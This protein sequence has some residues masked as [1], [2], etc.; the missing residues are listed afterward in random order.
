MRGSTMPHLE[1]NNEEIW[2]RRAWSDEERSRQ[3]LL[4]EEGVYYTE[5]ERS[6]LCLLVCFLLQQLHHSW[7]HLLGFDARLGIEV[8]KAER[9]L[10]STSSMREEAQASYCMVLWN[11]PRL[12]N[13]HIAERDQSCPKARC[14][15]HG[16]CH[17]QSLTRTGCGLAQFPLRYEHR[18][19]FGMPQANVLPI[20]EPLGE[21]Q[22]LAVPFLGLYK[23]ASTHLKLC[24]VRENNGDQGAIANPLGKAARTTQGGMGSLVFATIE[25][26]VADIT[27]HMSNFAL[28]VVL[29][30]KSESASQMGQGRGLLPNV[31]VKHP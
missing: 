29:F 23:V 2:C 19:Q 15:A 21:D 20:V 27:R 4:N 10:Y 13:A 25:M 31:I 14:V 8:I 24:Q 26:N 7:K 30:V 3:T 12:C 17:V 22:A 6:S 1:G 28:S 18:D 9:T 16:S 5:S 11:C